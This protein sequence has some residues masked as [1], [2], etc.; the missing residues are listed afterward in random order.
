MEYG[1]FY[2]SQHDVLL[3]LCFLATL[4]R[5]EAA[6]VAQEA[7]TRAWERW[8]RIA[9]TDPGAWSRTVALNSAARAGDVFGATALTSPFPSAPFPS[10]P[11]TRT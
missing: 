8:D 11:R 9:D 1:D 3:R 2:R 10:P 7:L 6:D 4:D 5:G